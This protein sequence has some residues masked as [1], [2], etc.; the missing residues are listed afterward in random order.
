MLVA[1]GRPAVLTI[2]VRDFD[3]VLASPTGNVAVSVEDVDETVVASGNASQAAAGIYTYTLPTAVTG[4]LGVY[5]AT[6]TYTMS[7]SGYSQTIPVETVGNYLFEMHELRGFDRALENEEH[8]PAADLRAAR[9]AV[10][11]DLETAAQVAFAPRA[12]RVTLSGNGW[13]EI[14]LPDVRVTEVD[15]VTLYD[16]DLGADDDEPIIGDELIDCEADLHTGIVTR[17]DGN[18]FPVGSNNVVIDY[19]HGYEVTPAPIK[20]AALILAAEYLIKSQ[21]PARA[22]SVSN[23]LGDFRISVANEDL[24]RPTGIPAVDSAIQKYGYRRP[25]TGVG[26]V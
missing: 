6:A 23:D 18:I 19:V 3:G 22:T 25:A 13:A 15:A 12:R 21:L 20:Q 26:A 7:G 24:N 8:Y 14:F 5:T 1:K 17:T 9:E 11:M 10:T 2:E 16:E 4:T